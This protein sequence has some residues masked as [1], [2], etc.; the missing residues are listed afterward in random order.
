MPERHRG[1]RAVFDY[2]WEMLGEEERTLFSQLSCFRGGFTRDAARAVAGA[3]PRDLARLS[4]K[5]FLVANP[6]SGRFVVHELLR[7]Y[8]AESLA[9]DQALC[10]ET[11]AKHVQFYVERLEEADALI[12]AG[13]QPAA[14]GLVEADLGNIR[15]A[16]NA[17]ITG[18][19]SNFSTEAALAFWFSYEVRG[20]HLPGAQLFGDA[21]GALL[22]CADDALRLRALCLACQ[23]WFVGLTGDPEQGREYGDQALAI[24][25]P[26]APDQVKFFTISC[27]NINLLY[28][29][30]MEDMYAITSPAIAQAHDLGIG[31]WSNLM[32]DW[33]SHA[34]FGLGRLA[35]A[36][37]IAGAA[38][39]HWEQTNDHWG[40]IWSLGV[41][42]MSARAEDRFD[43]ARDRYR[44][45]LSV[46]Q[47]LGFRRGILHTLN[48]LG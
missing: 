48:N 14:V 32:R 12:L 41:L 21:A 26:L 2:S 38:Q 16:W 22:H 42:A 47:E 13:S 20:W 45:L 7:Q 24:L 27:R 31:R 36:Q 6:D 11:I 3:S 40:M 23:S 19:G 10:D 1:M 33:T 17:A 25:E 18:G 5:S 43:E 4:N 8:G 29:G 37:A 15:A 35:E 46:N 34:L 28:S 9:A 30:A 44:R 39:A